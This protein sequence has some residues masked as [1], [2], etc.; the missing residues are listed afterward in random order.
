MTSFVQAVVATALVVVGSFFL[1]IG[2]VGI[3]RLPDVYNRMHATSKATTLGAASMFLA[4]FVVFG[5]G[6]PDCTGREGY[7]HYH[8]HNDNT[9]PVAHCPSLGLDG[10]IGTAYSLKNSGCSKGSSSCS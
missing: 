1:F 2:T 7:Y 4:G 6:D 8:R 3:L 9:R 5:P 10:N